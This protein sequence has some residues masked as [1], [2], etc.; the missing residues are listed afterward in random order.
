VSCAASAA[1]IFTYWA[2]LELGVNTFIAADGRVGDG[3]ESG[4]VPLNNAQA[5]ASSPS[6]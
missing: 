3:P 6:T 1:T 4:P 5:A 2:G